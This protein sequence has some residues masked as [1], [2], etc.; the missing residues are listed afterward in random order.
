MMAA[1]LLAYVMCPP[2]GMYIHDSIDNFIHKYIK[3]K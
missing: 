3:R 1:I 2:L